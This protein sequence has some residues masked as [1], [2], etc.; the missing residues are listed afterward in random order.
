MY[1][2]GKGKEARKYLLKISLT[3]IYMLECRIKYFKNG[4]KNE[5]RKQ[6]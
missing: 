3:L 6:Y 4:V 2:N 1:Y 5:S